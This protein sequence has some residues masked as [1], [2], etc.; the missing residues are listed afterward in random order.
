MDASWC[1]LQKQQK[2]A[3]VEEGGNYKGKILDH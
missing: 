3:M 1:K 2:P